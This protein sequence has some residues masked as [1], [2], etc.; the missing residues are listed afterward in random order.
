MTPPLNPPK[1]G[2]IRIGITGGIGSGKSMVSHL[3]RVFG[4]PVYVSDVE[5]KRLMASDLSIRRELQTLLGK[6]VYAEGRLDKSLLASYLFASPEHAR[7][8]NA[9][10][11]PRVKADF[12]AWTER[13]AD[14][15]MAGIE[16]AILIEAGFRDVVD[17]VVLVTAP[18]ELRIVRAMRRD[19]AARED[20][21]RRIRSQMSD[22]EKRR[23]ADYVILND[24]L[25]PL[26]PQVR[27]L[28]SG[29][30]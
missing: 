20:I 18:E 6:D 5:T 10:V 4:V 14:C 8:V 23:Y 25:T 12:R 11:H 19:S 1:G 9:I 22:D 30:V 29:I 24:D 16:S 27:K 3:L 26:I 13:H 17:R 2:C 7:R 15:P 21:V 28:L